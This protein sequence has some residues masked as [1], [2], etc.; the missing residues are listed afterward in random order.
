MHR[1]GSSKFVSL[2]VV[3]LLIATLSTV[4]AADNKKN[5]PAP[6][7][8]A[9][10]QAP[11]SPHQAPGAPHQSQNAPHPNSGP[12]GGANGMN[13]GPGGNQNQ[14]G[15]RGGNQ[16][17]MGNR[18]G[19][20]NQQ[21]NRGGNQNQMGNRGNNQNQQGNRN[22]QNQ[23]GNRGGNQNQQGNRNQNQMGNRG[24]QPGNRGGNQANN[25]GHQPAGSKTVA[26]KNGG[27]ATFRKDGKVRTIQTKNGMK[28][29]HGLKGQRKVVAQ[30]NGRSVVAMGRHGGYSQRAYYRN[31]NRTY[32]QRT[33]VVGGRTYAYAYRSYYYGG[34]P[35]YGYAPA[36][37]YGPAYY[38]W[39]YNPWPAPV[40]YNWGYAGQPWYGYYGPYYQPYPSYPYASL[41]LTDYLISENLRLAYAAAAA[42]QG[43]LT[44][45]QLKPDSSEEVASLWTSDPLIDASIAAAYQSGVYLFGAPTPT[46]TSGPQLSPEVKQAISE[47]MKKE[48]AAEKDAAANKDKNND[49]TGDQVPAALDPNTRYFV[50]SS[51]LDLT[52]SDGDECELTQGDVI[53]RTGDTPDDDRMVDATVKA[54]KKDECSVGATVGVE[55]NDLQEMHN[56]LRQTM[57]AGL[58]EL[59]NNSGKNGL[60]TAPDTKTTAGEVP[61]PAPDSNVADDLQ[62]TQKEADQAEAEAQQPN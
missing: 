16:N 7:P 46:K 17:Q 33:Y 37:Y 12:G 25:R 19:N 20:Q 59:A 23:M 14:Q 60:P 26:L 34:Y 32:V 22:N 56:A 24:N 62:Q 36:Y 1:N 31:G 5:A 54:S 61:A 29:E 45:P 48:I 58:K 44:A 21:G 18:G 30:H 42:E 39:A 10:H 38:G 55:V 49:A 41:W 43:E 28:I 47:Q 27:Q 57:D 2:A 6:P 51:N 4:H 9:P 8:Q 13:R 53:Y 15:N 11:G 52:T 40:Y 50:V 35:Y 3:L